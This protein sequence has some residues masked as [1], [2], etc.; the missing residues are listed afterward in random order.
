DTAAGTFEYGYECARAA[1]L[2]E[3]AGGTA[4]SAAPQGSG[5]VAALESVW[6]LFVLG[7][8]EQLTRLRV[9]GVFYRTM[10]QHLARLE[11]LCK[12]VEEAKART[13]NGSLRDTDVARQ[14]MAQ[15]DRLLRE[16]GRNVRLGKLL[17]ERLMEPLVSSYSRELHE[18]L[19]AQEAI[20]ERIQHIATRA[21]HLDA[22]LLPPSPSTSPAASPQAHD[23]GMEPSPASSLSPEPPLEPPPPLPHT[24]S[25]SAV[26]G[27]AARADHERLD[28]ELSGGSSSEYF[29]CRCS[30]GTSY[31]T[32]EDCQHLHDLL[33]DHDRPPSEEGQVLEEVLMSV[34]QRSRLRSALKKSHSAG[35]ARDVA[36]QV[37]SEVATEA[38]QQQEEEE[39]IHGRSRDRSRTSPSSRSHTRSSSGRRGKPSI[40][41]DAAGRWALSRSRSTSL[42]KEVVHSFLDFHEKVV[43]RNRSGSQPRSASDTL[44]RELEED[45]RTEDERWLQLQRA[46]EEYLLG[47]RAAPRTGELELS[48]SDFPVTYT[49]GVPEY[50]PLT[51]RDHFDAD[52]RDDASPEHPSV[53]YHHQ[54][55]YQLPRTDSHGESVADESLTKWQQEY[56]HQVQKEHLEDL[57]RE[58]QEEERASRAESQ[59][60]RFEVEEDGVGVAARKDDKKVTLFFKDRNEI[61]DDHEQPVLATVVLGDTAASSIVFHANK[62]D[63]SVALVVQSTEHDTETEA[64]SAAPP[65]GAEHFPCPPTELIIEGQGWVSIPYPVGSS[66]S[67]PHIPDFPLLEAQPLVSSP[68][69]YSPSASDSSMHVQSKPACNTSSATLIRSKSFPS[70]TEYFEKGTLFHPPSRKLHNRRDVARNITISCKDTPSHISSHVLEHQHRPITP[71]DDPPLVPHEERQKCGRSSGDFQPDTDDGELTKRTEKYLSECSSEFVR[72]EELTPFERPDFFRSPHYTDKT[73][74]VSDPSLVEEEEDEKREFATIDEII[75]EE[76]DGHPAQNTYENVHCA[77]HIPRGDSSYVSFDTQELEYDSTPPRPALPLTTDEEEFAPPRPTLPALLDTRPLYARQPSLPTIPEEEVITI[78]HSNFLPESVT[79]DSSSPRP[80]EASSLTTPTVRAED[81]AAV[82]SLN[83]SSSRDDELVENVHEEGARDDDDDDGGGGDDKEFEVIQAP[84]EDASASREATESPPAPPTRHYSRRPS[85][86]ASTEEIIAWKMQKSMR[87][88]RAEHRK[89]WHYPNWCCFRAIHGGLI[90]GRSVSEHESELRELLGSLA[91]AA[92]GMGSVA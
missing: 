49:D 5:A 33:D 91:G 58:R 67:A 71:E 66:A 37:A 88:R 55:Q 61:E 76:D 77:V 56:L 57:E 40:H 44:N 41:P 25:A 74:I 2:V 20:S 63:S 59:L 34:P 79:F 86:N 69:Q 29:S 17:K 8:Q 48:A 85:S 39:R 72:Y 75:A 90:Y 46:A 42:T 18:N 92:Y 68:T 9:A 82:S 54:E 1:M 73:F 47:A 51:V 19:L 26:S 32:C 21:R 6:K 16:I 38:L 27:V 24:A 7:S 52:G 53:A 43:R 45:Q 84:A 30:S 80:D 10:E 50:V 78:I 4:A 22:L 62:G 87:L 13:T 12:S 36:A 35:D 14:L 31:H 11:S 23:S 70:L 28:R 60:S 81:T 64:S 15:R 3:K 83:D 65:V 89:K